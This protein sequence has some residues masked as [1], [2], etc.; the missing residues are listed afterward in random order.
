MDTLDT[1]D[2]TEQA[3]AAPDHTSTAPMQ[4]ITIEFNKPDTPHEPMDETTN[5]SL[6][7][8]NLSAILNSTMEEDL[9][10]TT[11]ISTHIGG[12]EDANRHNV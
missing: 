1:A 11:T 2:L 6:T 12:V 4:E 10:N 7:G 9:Q 8:I 3:G 5:A